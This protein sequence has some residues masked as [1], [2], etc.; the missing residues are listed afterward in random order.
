MFRGARILSLLTLFVLAL[1]VLVPVASAY[2]DR[3]GDRVVIGKDE[4]INDDLFVGAITVVV[5]GTVNG[6]L[7]AGGQTVTINGSVTGNVF[8]AGSAVTVNGSVGQDVVAGGV[9]VTIGPNARI[10]YNAYTFGASVESQSGSQIGGSLVVG[11]GQGLISGQTTNDLAAATSRLRLDGTVGRNA[12][13]SV[14]SSASRSSPGYYVRGAPAMPSVPAGLT[15]GPEAQVAGALEYVSPETIAVPPSVNTQVTHTLPPQ[16]QQLSRELAQRQSTSNYVFDAARG[17]VGLLL[18]GLLIAWLAPR[19]ITGPADM[20]LSKPLPSLGVG[21]VGLVAA[22]ISWLLA[23]GVVVTVAVIFGLLSLGGLTALT[24]LA[25]LP[26]LGIAF[27]AFLFIAS[28]LCEAIVAYL[29]GRLILRQVRPEW[30]S[31]IY[32]PLLVGLL[33]LGVLFALPVV[34]GWLQFLVVL[35]GLGAIG[36]ALLQDRPAPQTPAEVAASA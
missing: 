29:G 35:A 3:R 18:V 9:A 23:L 10:G 34:G 2:D 28:Y 19:W 22:P 21:L 16:D 17:L 7:V 25:G 27:V 14:G 32:G 1:F 4:V 8:A 24:L 26:G 36:L 6:D 30:N 33:I 5:D 12:K 13:I 15:F 20:L 11:A 31:R